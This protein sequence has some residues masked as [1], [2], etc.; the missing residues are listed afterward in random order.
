MSSA[1]GQNAQSNGKEKEIYFI[2]ITPKEEKLNFNDYKFLS[3]IIPQ[4]IFYN[5]IKK[6]SGSSIEEN[7][8]KLNIKIK[9]TGNEK[10][11]SHQLNQLNIIYLL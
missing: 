3:E 7:V 8:F 1:Q 9:E 4:K 6:V 10:K 5:N 2:I 11:K